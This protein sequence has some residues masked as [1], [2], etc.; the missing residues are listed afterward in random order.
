MKYGY[1]SEEVIQRLLGVVRRPC[2]ELVKRGILR[3]VEPAPGF[4]PAYV[5]AHGVLDEAA[6]AYE[7]STGY[8]PPAYTHHK[9]SIPFIQN[10]HHHIQAQLVHLQ[11]KSQLEAADAEFSDWS[12]RELLVNNDREATPDI[13]FVIVDGDDDITEWHEIER[14]RKNDEALSYKLQGRAKALADGKFQRIF[15]HCG[16][17]A[18]ARRIR[19]ILDQT[20]VLRLTKNKNGTHTKLTDREG[21]NPADLRAAT[22]ISR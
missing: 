10:F 11:R 3:R 5:L 14:T 8:F 13:A 18:I 20:R 9:S 15:W 7:M 6:A 1:T 4:P 2:A 12:E 16:S 22:V 19:E 17:P 21:W